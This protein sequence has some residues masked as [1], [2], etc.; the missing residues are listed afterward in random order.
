MK[1]NELYVGDNLTVL[2]QHV[3]ADSIDLV[4][5]DPPFNSKKDYYLIFANGQHG[6]RPRQVKA[7]DDTW[8]W[9]A[10]AEQ[11]CQR[12]SGPVRTLVDTLHQAIGSNDVMAYIAMMAERLVE[13]HRVLKS[14]G[15]SYLHCDPAASHYLK[16]LMDAIFGAGNFRREIVWRSGWVSG[17]KAAARNWA[18]NHDVLLYYVKDRQGAWTFNKDKA[19]VPHPADYRRRG[20]GENPKGVATDDVWTDIYSPWI[21]SFSG[22]KR[23]WPTQKPVALLKRIIEV[24]TNEGDV[25]LD[26]FCGCGTTLVAAEELGR[27][28]IGI[29][30]NPLAIAATKDRLQ[31]NPARRPVP[32]PRPP[33]P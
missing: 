32:G 8:H 23:G 25:V 13:V 1:R 29:D 21:M 30:V 7:F 20:G 14:T 26:P 17:F 2:R 18:R 22:E 11:A 16:T 24:S 27:R 28:W 10:A 4:Y 33:A 31:Q 3:A 6:R 19:F 5:L 9:D 12:L 15:S